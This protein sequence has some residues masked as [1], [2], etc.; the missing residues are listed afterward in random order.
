MRHKEGTIMTRANAL[1]V[2]VMAA[3]A[4]P[5]LAGAA[6]ESELQSA[7]FRAKPA[8]VM[9]AV[10]IGATATVRC[11]NGR[12]RRSIPEPSGRSGAAPSSILTA[13]S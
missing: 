9:V 7:V 2:T 3:L 6:T 13:G 1:V 12:A 5:G 10:R 8:V 11:G 4:L